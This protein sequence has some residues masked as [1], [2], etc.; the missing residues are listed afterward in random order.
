MFSCQ[1]IEIA[2]ESGWDRTIDTLIKSQRHDET[3]RD[4]VTRDVRHNSLVAKDFSTPKLSYLSWRD[5]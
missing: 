2:G 1:H 3:A 5:S 4:A